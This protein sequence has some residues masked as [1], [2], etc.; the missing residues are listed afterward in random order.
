MFKVYTFSSKKI[1]ILPII[2]LAIIALVVLAF[3]AI[4][5]LILL[6][7][8]ILFGIIFAVWFWLKYNKNTKIKI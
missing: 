8:I 7:I 3:A 2:V 5:F 6:P 1:G 4:L